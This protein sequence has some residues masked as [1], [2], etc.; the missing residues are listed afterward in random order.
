[1]KRLML[2]CLVLAGCDDGS[3]G[4]TCYSNH[5]CKDDLI[6]VQW[7]IGSGEQ[8]R[9]SVCVEASTLVV[10]GFLMPKPCEECP[11]PVKCAMCAPTVTCPVCKECAPGWRRP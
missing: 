4:A 2:L 5:T 8:G 6:C 3:K 10:G 1:M 7:V 9:R 11:P